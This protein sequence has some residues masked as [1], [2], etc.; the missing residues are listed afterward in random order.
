MITNLKNDKLLFFLRRKKYPYKHRNKSFLC[1]ALAIV[2]LV[3]TAV[4]VHGLI[5]YTYSKLD[6]CDLSARTIYKNGVEPIED[7]AYFEEKT[8]NTNSSGDTVPNLELNNKTLTL[9]PNG[10]NGVHITWVYTGNE[11]FEYNG[12]YQWNELIGIGKTFS[13]NT[14]QGYRTAYDTNEVELSENGWYTVFAIWYEEGEKLH[15]VKNFHVGSIETSGVGTEY[16]KE[17]Y[18]TWN[19]NKKYVNSVPGVKNYLFIGADHW[20]RSELTKSYS[21]YMVLATVNTNNKEVSFTTI[22]KESYV[23]IPTIGCGR[24]TNAYNCGGVE[25]VVRT[26]EENCGLKIDNYLLLDYNYFI[27][28]INS[29]KGIKVQ[30]EKYQVPYINQ[31]ISIMESNYRLTSDIVR[32]KYL[33]EKSGEFLLD[34]AQT[35]AYIRYYN[36]G[37]WARSERYDRMMKG[38]YNSVRKTRPSVIVNEIFPLFTTDFSF[39]EY[40]EFLYYLPLYL[41]Y[42]VKA[43]ELPAENRIAPF[44]E[45]YRYNVLLNKHA[46]IDAVVDDILNDKNVE[47][48]RMWWISPILLIIY[49]CL[50]ILS[51]TALSYTVLR[52]RRVIY[53]DPVSGVKR[54]KSKKYRWNSDVHVYHQDVLGEYNGNLFMNK[55]M[56]QRYSHKIKMPMHELLVYAP[57]PAGD[58]TDYSKDKSMSGGTPLK[59]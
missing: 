5:K 48:Q 2:L 9:N 20:D 4:L 52:K 40:K 21:D 26:I 44:K 47:H 43:N 28:M 7:Q 11:R 56:T 3:L 23:Y 17:A 29:V 27:Q 12:N 38:F 15:V 37:D 59:L 46:E 8:V 49:F 25:L 33:E 45:S 24:L 1:W 6:I 50:L 14:G 13:Y 36:E 32:T 58:N 19:D 57:I 30:I 54:Y 35:L 34:G 16:E 42:D 22:L 41:K 39:D 31:Y 53:I 51:V 55:E 18:D 10:I